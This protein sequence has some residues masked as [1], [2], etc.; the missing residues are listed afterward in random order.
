MNPDSTIA[1]IKTVF[2]AGGRVSAWKFRVI[3]R[4]PLLKVK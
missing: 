3:R 1:W 2:H 4:A